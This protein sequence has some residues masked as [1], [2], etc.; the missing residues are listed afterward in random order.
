MHQIHLHYRIEKA[1]SNKLKA[2]ASDRLGLAT[3]VKT[4]G[5]QLYLSLVTLLLHKCE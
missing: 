4:S 3:V 1:A 5:K 2:A